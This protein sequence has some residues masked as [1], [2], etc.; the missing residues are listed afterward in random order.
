VD[1]VG[2]A[3]VGLSG[4]WVAGFRET[5]GRCDGA[6]ESELGLAVGELGGL[7][8]VGDSVMDCGDEDCSTSGVAV[9]AAELIDADCGFDGNILEAAGDPLAG[10]GAFAGASDGGSLRGPGVDTA[11][12]GNGACVPSG[13]PAGLGAVGS[14]ALGCGIGSTGFDGVG[15]PSV[16][17]DESGLGDCG[18]EWGASVRCRSQQDLSYL[19]L[20][21]LHSQLK[22]P[23]IALS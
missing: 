21:A 1:A 11:G 20:H 22:R 19:F 14:T 16:G 13:E 6:L 18:E 15:G 4:T 7:G 17:G 8:P 5:R 2:G 12:L 3:S 10:N 9:G 23:S